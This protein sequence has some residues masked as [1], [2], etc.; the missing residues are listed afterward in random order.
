MASVY[1]FSAADIDGNQR[2]LADFRGT[3]LL[4]VNTASKCGFTYQYKGLEALHRAYAGKGAE[5]L[6]FPCNQFRQQEPGSAEEIKNFCSLTYDVTFPMFAKIDVNGPNTHPLY[7]FLENEKRGMFGSK[8][9]KW[10]FTKFLIGKDGSVLARYGPTT[11]PEAI[12]A[13]IDK[14]L[15][16]TERKPDAA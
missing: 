13:D 14:A 1:D 11:N 9:I 6:G 4:I 3:V 7:V 5:V 2:A 8:S 10:N 15:N 16:G 12:K